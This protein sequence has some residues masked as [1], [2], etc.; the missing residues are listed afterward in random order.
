MN[1]GSTTAQLSLSSSPV[2]KGLAAVSQKHSAAF[3]AKLGA[4]KPPKDLVRSEGKIVLS[5]F[6]SRNLDRV[7][8][9]SSA[10]LRKA[11]LSERTPAPPVLSPEPA[12]RRPEA[13]A[14][15]LL[16]LKDRGTAPRPARAKVSTSGVCD[17]KAGGLSPEKGLLAPKERLS[18]VESSNAKVSSPKLKIR[19]IKTGLE[20][21]APVPFDFLKNK[22]QK[23][24]QN[25]TLD[26]RL[27]LSTKEEK[28]PS[29]S[30]YVPILSEKTAESFKPQS[31]LS[32]LYLASFSFRDEESKERLRQELEKQILDVFPH[33]LAKSEGEQQVLNLRY[34]SFEKI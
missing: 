14:P 20:T 21:P 22:T 33:G 17:R 27:R 24:T 1:D 2:K 29:D 28:G 26:S 11:A 19:S 7:E 18:K 4:A 25:P 13:K 5:K 8:E 31:S 30:A 3:Q 9:K 34:A 15:A 32:E 23:V 6:T 16:V 10:P 12:G